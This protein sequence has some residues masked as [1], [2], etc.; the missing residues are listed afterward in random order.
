MAPVDLNWSPDSNTW[1]VTVDDE[2]VSCHD[3]YWEAYERFCSEER[4]YVP[5]M[6]D[7]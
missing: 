1:E 3:D 4:R 2:F 6:E 5:K 7:A